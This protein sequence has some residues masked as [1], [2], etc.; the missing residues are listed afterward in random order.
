VDTAGNVFITGRMVGTVDFGSGAPG[1]SASDSFFSSSPRRLTDGKHV[2]SN[3][4]GD[5]SAQIGY[6]GSPTTPASD[7][8][9]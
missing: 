1:V 3:A 9:S 6:E 5:D 8:S 4:F 7:T 2:W